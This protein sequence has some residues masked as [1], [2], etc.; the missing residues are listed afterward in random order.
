M[1]IMEVISSLKQHVVRREA[2]YGRI[3]GKQPAESDNKN[4]RVGQSVAV[5]TVTNANTWLHGTPSLGRCQN[6]G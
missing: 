2:I 4:R 5:V 3:N 1:Q 6:A